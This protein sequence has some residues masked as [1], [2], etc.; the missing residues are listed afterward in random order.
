MK[1]VFDVC[2]FFKFGS[3][4]LFFEFFTFAS[5]FGRCE[6]FLI[7]VKELNRK[8]YSGIDVSQN[9][10]VYGPIWMSN[11]PFQIWSLTKNHSTLFNLKIGNHN[12]DALFLFVYNKIKKTFQFSMWKRA[13]KNGNRILVI[14]NDDTSEACSN[15]VHLHWPSCIQANIC[16]MQPI[17]IWTTTAK[18]TVFVKGSFDVNKVTWEVWN[19]LIMF[20]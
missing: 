16:I 5:T 7:D 20:F 18:V 3:F 4:S 1:I 9:H 12:M 15:K 6:K 19:D 10:K 14:Y 8:L 17:I 2:F 13:K 11:I